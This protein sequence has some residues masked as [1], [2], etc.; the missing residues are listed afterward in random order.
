MS[1][2]ILAVI[3]MFL[4][5]AYVACSAMFG[6]NMMNALTGKG[7]DRVKYVKTD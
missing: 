1:G 2:G 6:A 7:P 4:V 3:A 5:P